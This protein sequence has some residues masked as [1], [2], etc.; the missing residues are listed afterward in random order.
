MQSG[1]IMVCAGP[2]LTLR[3]LFL[4]SLIHGDDLKMV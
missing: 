4:I 1:G 2:A 3:I